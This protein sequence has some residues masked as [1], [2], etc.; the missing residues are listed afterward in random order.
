M[1]L[2]KGARRSIQKKAICYQGGM[3]VNIAQCFGLN[4]MAAGNVNSGKIDS[5]VVCQS[6]TAY[7][8]ISVRNGRIVGALDISD[9]RCS[10]IAYWAARKGLDCCLLENNIST[11]NIK[12]LEKNLA[13]GWI[14]LS[15]LFRLRQANKINFNK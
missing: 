4:I 7:R 8:K 14:G 15:R 5:E 12:Q 9:L 1:T 13:S 6:S 10:G 2:S 11:I 3:P